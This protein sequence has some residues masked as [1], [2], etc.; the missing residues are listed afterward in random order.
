MNKQNNIFDLIIIGAGPAGVAAGV[1]A[2]R[3]KIKTL[4][5][6]KDFGGQSVVSETIENWV[7]EISISGEDLAKKLEDHIKHYKSSNFVIKE[8][9][10]VESIEKKEDKIFEVKINLGD[11]FQTKTILINTGAKRRKLTVPGADKFEHKGLT[12][13]ASCDGPLFTDKDVVVIGGGNAGFESASQLL[14]YCKS[15]TLLH[16][17]EKYN[18]EETMVEQVL[19]N[20]KMTGILQANIS[21]IFGSEFVEGIK[22]R[23]D[24]DEKI[25]K[26]F[27][28]FV[29][30]GAVPASDFISS[31]LVEKNKFKEIIVDHKTCQS[32]QAGIWAAGDI[33]DGLYKQNGIAIGDGVKAIEDIY[34]Y[35]QKN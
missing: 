31:N 26:V 23:V 27:G 17:N 28:V 30:I 8:F 14:A 6:T 15:V 34:N 25:L 19:S 10:F 20:R 32:S 18:A 1:Y 22:Y 33:N 12:Y 9:A 5:I 21:E 11:T 4:L 7:G 29:E 24:G 16:R 2:A 35:L 3:K 13:C